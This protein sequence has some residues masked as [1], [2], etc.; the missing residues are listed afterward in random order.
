MNSPKEIG[1]CLSEIKTESI[2]NP[3]N[4]SLDQNKKIS[5]VFDE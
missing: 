1:S 5:L 4:S 3:P 2:E